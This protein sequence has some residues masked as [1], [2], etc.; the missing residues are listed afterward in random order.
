MTPTPTKTTVPTTVPSTAT[1]VPTTKPTTPGGSGGTG[2]PTVTQTMVPTSLQ[3]TAPPTVAPTPTVTIP[4]DLCPLVPAPTGPV[5]VIT[6]PTVITEP[7][8]YRIGTDVYNTTV[9][10]W[11]DIRVSDVTI[12]GNGHT[13]DG[14]DGHGTYG[15]RVRGDGGAPHAREGRALGP[16]LRH[17]GGEFRRR[18][19]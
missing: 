1:T 15:I 10:V 17:Q 8:F 13:I 6:A 12:D 14:I 16:H 3:T 9:P 18:D 11:L 19:C 4:G 5:T 7:G 2:T